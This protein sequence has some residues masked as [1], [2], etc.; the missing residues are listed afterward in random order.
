MDHYS[1]L[2]VQRNATPD[3]IKTA[4]RK[5]A[6]KHHP[7]KGGDTATFQAI[8]AAYEILSDP[9]K[10]HSY[11]N[12]P[13]HHSPFGHS[14]FNNPEDIFRHFFNQHNQP[15]NRQKIYT[16]TVFVSLEQVAHGT[17]ENIQIGTP[18][19][20]K[21]FQIRVPRGIED[22]QNVRYEKLMPDGLLQVCFRIYKHKVFDRRGNDIHVVQSINVFDLIIGTKITVPDIYEKMLELTIPANTKPGAIFRIPGHGLVTDHGAGDQYVLIQPFIPDTISPELMD[23]LRKERGVH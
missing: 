22:G 5:L 17:T 14:P 11:D 4:Y 8:Q 13:Q 20:A 2:G 18:D 15:Q 23:A 1:T 9:E 21:V 12:P 6:S 3:E 19:G 7:D 10:R 16:V